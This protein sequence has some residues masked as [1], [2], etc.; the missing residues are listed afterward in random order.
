MSACL[1]IG[2]ISDKELDN[3]FVA[4]FV[5]LSEPV[6]NV[7]EGLSISDIINK[8]DA[9]SS[10]VVGGSDGLEPLLPC[11]VPDL[12]LNRASSRLE[13]PDLK[14]DS[15]RGKE[16][17]L[18]QRYLSLKMLS[19]NLRRRLDLPTEELPMSSSLNR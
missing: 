5:D 3:I 6:L 18:N 10:F 8:D 17:E 9:M 19:E 2:F 15:N 11:S 1:Q 13:G 14:V 16:T 7:L 12:Q 4:V